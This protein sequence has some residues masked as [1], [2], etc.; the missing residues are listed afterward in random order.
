MQLSP[1]GGAR[2]GKQ[3][4]HTDDLVADPDRSLRYRVLHRARK[5]HPGVGRA[6]K[7]VGRKA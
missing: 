1:V 3:L 6:K 2:Q 4:A 7:D 5:A